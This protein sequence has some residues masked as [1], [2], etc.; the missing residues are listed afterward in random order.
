[1][2]VL[3]TRSSR[4]THR[5]AHPLENCTEVSTGKITQKSTIKQPIYQENTNSEQYRRGNENTSRNFRADYVCIHTFNAVRIS[6]TSPP[7]ETAADKQ[8]G[9]NR[10]KVHEFVP[11][12]SRF[13][14]KPKINL[15]FHNCDLN[16]KIFTIAKKRMQSY[17]VCRSRWKRTEKSNNS[18]AYNRSLDFPYFCQLLPFCPPF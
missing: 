2:L 15:I 14:S 11:H 7:Q 13:I 5:M 3:L 6:G 8:H 9:T 18:E 4:V 12:P 1:M 10:G 16:F 17:P